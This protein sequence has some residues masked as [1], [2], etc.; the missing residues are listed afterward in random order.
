LEDRPSR[1]RFVAARTGKLEIRCFSK[2]AYGEKHRRIAWQKTALRG[3]AR[4]IV[5]LR[6]KERQNAADYGS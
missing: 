6:G 1:L 5:A 3:M 2:K 4:Q